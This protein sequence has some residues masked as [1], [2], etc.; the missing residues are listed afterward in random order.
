[1]PAEGYLLRS[2]PFVGSFR[3]PTG[4]YEAEVARS[5]DEEFWVKRLVSGPLAPP[6]H[7]GAV[8]LC[9]CCKTPELGKRLSY[10]YRE[11]TQRC[12][13]CVRSGCLAERSQVIR[14]T[15][16]RSSECCAPISEWRQ[17]CEAEEDRLERARALKRQRLN[18]RG[19]LRVLL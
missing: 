17:R 16:E 14:W 12:R 3:G 10:S 5:R 13:L 1:M 8:L 15:T 6:F 11:A 4:G 19:Q 18:Y 9:S 7:P 2:G